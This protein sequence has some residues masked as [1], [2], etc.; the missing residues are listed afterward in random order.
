MSSQFFARKALAAFAVYL[1]AHAAT[2]DIT[3]NVFQDFNSNG[4][5]DTATTIANAGSGN[6][7]IGVAVDGLLANVTVTATCVTGNGPDGVYGTADDVRTTYASVVTDGANPYT[8]TTS[9]APVAGT[10]A[11]P[12]CRVS[13]SWDETTAIVSGLPNPLYGMRPAFVGTGSNTATQFVNNG[14][15]NADLGLNYP[16]D[17]CQNNP[18]LATNCMRFGASDNATNGPRTA[19]NGFPYN[20]FSVGTTLNPATPTELARTNQVGSTWG[21]AF[22]KTQKKLLA[23]AYLKRNIGLGSGGLGQIYIVDATNTAGQSVA[24]FLNLEVLKPGSAGPNPRVSPVPVAGTSPTDPAGHPYIQDSQVL[25]G[26]DL[27]TGKLGIGDI[28][29]SDDQSTLYAIGLNS[30]KLYIIPVGA[31]L[32]APAA[33]AITEVSLP[34][35]GTVSGTGCPADATTP[36]GELN[37]NLRPFAL[38]SHKGSLYV[39]LTCTGESTGAIADLRA[40][41]Y[42]YDGGTSFT[43]VAN[44]TLNYTLENPVSWNQWRDT[45]DTGF[46]GCCFQSPE[47]LLTDIEFMPSGDML[48]GIRDRMG[49]ATGRGNEA[50]NGTTIVDGRAH[51]DLIRACYSAG[52]GLFDAD[53]CT[54]NGRSWSTEAQTSTFFPDPNN[55]MGGLVQVP[56]FTEVVTTVKDPSWIYSSG[57]GWYSNSTGTAVKPYEI[58]NNSGAANDVGSKGSTM[59]DMEALCDAAPIQIGNRVWFD[60]NANGLQDPG[61]PPIANVTVNL[62]RSGDTTPYATATTDANGNYYFSNRVTD[63]NGSALVSTASSIF[64]LTDLTPNT[65][66]F[67]IR[68]DNPSNYSA[69]GALENHKLT[70]PNVSGTSNNS[71]SDLNDSDA[72]LA[73][74]A[75]PIGTGN[76]PSITFD[77]GATGDNNF[78]LDVGLYDLYAI[79]NRIW[80]DTNNNGVLNSGE[81]TA[82]NVLVELLQGSTVVGTTSTNAAGEYV[83][84]NLPKGNYTVRVAASNWTG[85]T[86]AQA[87]AAGSPAL[88]GTS[89][90]AGYSN[91]TPDNA[92]PA[93]GAVG[94]ADGTDK[95]I[96]NA[97]PHTNGISSPTITLGPGNQPTGESVTTDNDGVAVVTT[98]TDADSNMAVDFGFYRLSVGDTLWFDNGAGTNKNNGIKDAG[99]N[100]LPA[101]VTVQLL[102]NNV[103]VA[104]TTT[105]ANGN[106]LFTAQTNG[107]PLAPGAD[108][109]VS[110]PSGQAALNGSFSSANPVAQT[111][112]SPGVGTNDDGDSGVGVADAFANATVTANF[113]LGASVSGTATP[114]ANG[115]YPVA[116]NGANNGTNHRPNVDLGFTTPSYSIGN[117]VWYD[118]N[119]NGILDAGEQP[120]AGVKVILLDSSGNPLNGQT[121]VT[122][123]AGY[124]R[125][126]AVTAGTY[127]VLVAPDNWTGLSGQAALGTSSGA[128]I[129]ASGAPLAGYSSSTAVT[130]VTSGTG[131]TNNNDKGIDPAN[132]AAYT[133]PAIA[134]GGVRSGPVTVGPTQQ[135]TTD[136]DNATPYSGSDAS[137]V[138]IEGNGND[139]L[140][141]DFGFYRLNVG[142][143]IWNDGV[144]S[145]GTP[146]DGIRNGTEP[147]IA[148]VAVQLVN[149]SGTVVAQT[150]TDANGN[151]SFNQLSNVPGV[152][153]GVGAAGTPNGQPILP[154]T[155][156][157]RVPGGQNVLAGA[158]SSADPSGGGQPAGDS[159]DNGTGTSPATGDTNSAA[160]VLTAV[161]ASLPA[162]AT[163]TNATGLTEQPRMDFAF[164][165]P[166]YAIGN[167]IWFDTNNN[168]VKDAGEASAP[169]VLVDLVNSSNTVVATTATNA[170]GE[171]IFDNLP[172]GTYTVRVASS[173]WAAGGIT[174][175]QATAAGNAALAGTR[176]LLGYANSTA[177]NPIPGTGAIGTADGTDKGVNSATPATSGISSPTIT[178]GPGPSPT[179]QLP[180]GESAAGD[181]DAAATTAAGD[182]NDNMAV[183]FGFYRLTAGNQ[184]WLETNGN[185]SYTSGTDATPPSVQGI[186]VELRDA[187]TNAV[188]ATTTT[189]TSG[190]YQ[191]V[192]L[193]NGNPIPA[194]AYYVSLPTLPAGTQPIPVGTALTDNNS[195]G[196]VPAAPIAGVAV[197]TG[198][199]NL[200]PGVTTENQTVTNATGTTA[201]PTLDMGFQAVYSLGNRVWVDVNNNGTV[202]P[203]ESGLDGVTVNLLDGTGAQLY[204]T[205]TGAITTVAAGNTAITTTTTSGGHYLFTNLPTGSYRVEIVT[206]TVGGASYVSSTGINGALTGPYEPTGA[207][208][209]ANTA[210]NFDHGVQFAPNTI[211]SLPITLGPGQPTGEDGNATPGQTDAT[212][213]NQ[214]NLTVDFG[215]FLPA[216]VG[217]VVWIDNGS[218]G[219]VSGDGIKQT[220]EPGIPGVGVQLL[221][222]SG[223]PVDGDPVTPG[224]QPI[225]TVTGPNGEYSIT[226]L[227]PGTYQVQFVFPPGARIINTVN[228]PGSGTPAVGPD[229]QRNEMSPST[230]RT[231]SITLAPGDNNPNLDS[232]VLTYDATPTVV[233]TLGEWAKWLLAMLLLGAVMLSTRRASSMRR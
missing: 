74:P 222:G 169:G 148:G 155:Y 197:R 40:F 55:P 223:N 11:N 141:V 18:T 37:L 13:F 8:I 129:T 108:Y 190:N 51:G 115:I 149:G 198:T 14:A 16:A 19:V 151:Y 135:P 156:T 201:Q 1:C 173:N 123:A 225:T 10:S 218:G 159:R 91:S 30:R 189:D 46:N 56:G 78:G 9:P 134:T 6:G 72:T 196:V 143:L 206:P 178:V 192:S 57:V 170:S 21:L 105:D 120:I 166:I 15:T 126:D 186:T 95:G 94:T 226:N 67:S 65:T 204:R 59:G 77:T 180:T 207:G 58:L 154:G 47:P 191:F 172:A 73:T 164:V 182:A 104:T 32:T 187:G 49:D 153:G 81:T 35:P 28:D 220:G 229:G 27:K 7:S 137:T 144:G 228:P 101:G 147:G 212:P 53:N 41:V 224:V 96:T 150:V 112:T 45:A 114:D 24:N 26:G 158:T 136:L 75:N 138:S 44:T 162:G 22:H 3:G 213:D 99:E 175:A 171:Y 43:Q 86:S 152:T 62:Y 125:F 31:S 209:I 106:Y 5:R 71:L 34:D 39:G 188:I 165:V 157:V 87:T 107:A 211:R 183:D 54:P 203:A 20:A 233:P 142:N 42:R 174:S 127:T 130:G 88:A 221:D 98:A 48:L 167:R 117:R 202:D 103:V 133:N 131:S 12:A 217:T 214:S 161:T 199:F 93:G 66:G 205:P 168:G 76:Y 176:P 185:S 89:P 177:S 85:I 50:L 17:F 232:G 102:K 210:T 208:T 70:T 194:G 193:N 80:F 184:I 52:T 64:G 163:Q 146:N 90:L 219:G 195:Q 119:N 231:P 38:K 122:D 139:N 4:V 36:V 230:Q 109:A 116:Q 60:A 128:G 100:G 83:F 69:G 23:S 124:Y 118:T 110:V 140:A 181:N 111:P 79:G 25:V 216:T 160:I 97:A 215:V 29:F 92:V 63:E 2:A 33:A 84:D 227:T 61:E 145:G 121:L 179:P 82:P 200:A 68:L 132:A 113:T